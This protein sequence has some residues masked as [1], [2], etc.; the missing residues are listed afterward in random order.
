MKRLI[1][2][3]ARLYPASWRRRYGDEFEALLE[4]SDATWRGVLDVLRGALMMHMNTRS[5]I[6]T[7]VLATLVGLLFGTAI[8]FLIPVGYSSAAAFLVTVPSGGNAGQRVNR[9]M[10]FA[11]DKDQSVRALRQ[12]IKIE[13]R[14]SLPASDPQ[15]FPGGTTTEFSVEIRHVNRPLAEKAA[16]TLASDLVEGNLRL[17][18]QDHPAG[19][20]TRL[21]IVQ[22]P[23]LRPDS[24]LRRWLAA[25]G[26]LGGFLIGF[27]IVA[28]PSHGR[29]TA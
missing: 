12:N 8:S 26:A 24:L 18:E 22:R 17:R 19:L 4:D 13:R 6:K 1:L 14:R 5:S 28:R 3:F 11:F 2:A 10:Q 25:S 9:L 21:Q 27:L 15:W 29:Q 16:R 20:P 7:V 23:S